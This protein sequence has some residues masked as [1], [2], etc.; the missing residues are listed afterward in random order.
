[1]FNF[2]LENLK[3]NLDDQDEIFNIE[4]NGLREMLGLKN[5]EISK[6]LKE[7]KDQTGDFEDQRQSLVQ[8]YTMLKNKIYTIERENELELYSVK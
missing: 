3:K 8:E 5:E 4:M 2:E 1:M 7:L 6:L